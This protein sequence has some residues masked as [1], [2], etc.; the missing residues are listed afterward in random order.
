M[1]FHSIFIGSSLEGLGIA[2]IIQ[3][4]LEHDFEIKLWTQDI[5]QPSSFCLQSLQ[6]NL[7]SSDFG[8][9]VFSPDDII[10]TRDSEHTVARDNVIFELGLFMGKLGYENC[11]IV[12][13]RFAENFH[14]PSDLIGFNTIDFNEKREDENIN[15]A[16]GPACT[17]IKRVIAK[18]IIKLKTKYKK[19][20]SLKFSDLFWLSETGNKLTQTEQYRN[21][22]IIA[23]DLVGF[24]NM[25]NK[26]GEDFCTLILKEIDKIVEQGCDLSYFKGG[27]FKR[28]GD[29]Y[30]IFISGPSDK[31]TLEIAK[32]I[33]SK[34]VDNCWSLFAPNLYINVSS[35]VCK[36][37]DKSEDI[38]SW[39]KRTMEHMK[40][41]KSKNITEVTFA[42]SIPSS[43]SSFFDFNTDWS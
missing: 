17:K 39:I 34:I 8:I 42:K 5:F 31:E 25:N 32:A 33:R 1:K 6:D 24:E 10:K 29:T 13:P 14:L 40:Y 4:Q 2:E 19:Q 23:Y 35:A 43:L 20:T 16:L 37:S 30:I 36:Y 9:F 11:F 3:E 28:I 12:K 18:R 15:A 22:F 38:L 7:N 27:I 21:C 41:V 26:Y